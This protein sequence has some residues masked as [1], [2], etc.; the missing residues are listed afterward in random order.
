MTPR[1]P[2]RTWFCSRDR[3]ASIFA[4]LHVWNKTERT[5]RNLLAV[6]RRHS[7]RA[8][9]GTNRPKF[10]ELT[11]DVI[12]IICM[13]NRADERWSRSKRALLAPLSMNAMSTS[14]NQSRRQHLRSIFVR[15]HTVIKSNKPQCCILP[16]HV[17][18]HTS[19]GVGI[20]SLI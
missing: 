12:R 5:A 9:I 13:H 4:T 14:G 20:N 17:S 7:H 16:K 19:H 18:P 15:S 3:I 11:A 10:V 1:K 2:G 8:N 6:R